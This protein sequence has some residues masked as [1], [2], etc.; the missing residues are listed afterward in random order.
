MVDVFQLI[1][2]DI[3]MSWDPRELTKDFRVI[4]DDSNKV[5]SLPN[6]EAHW[7]YFNSGI[8]FSRNIN[9]AFPKVCQEVIDT[10]HV[11]QDKFRSI[12]NKSAMVNL[13][14]NHRLD[15]NKVLLIKVDSGQS[16]DLHYDRTRSYSIN[17]GLKNSNTCLTHIYSGPKAE[18]KLI[19]ENNVKHTIRMNDGDAYILATS[20]PHCVES[21]SLPNENKDRYLI[22]YCLA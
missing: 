7:Q 10:L 22:S 17:I 3:S 21:L 12:D 1:G 13:F 16:V 4:V 20:Q 2:T 6:G 5:I 14:V 11:M 9:L 8:S 15:L 18:H 19:N